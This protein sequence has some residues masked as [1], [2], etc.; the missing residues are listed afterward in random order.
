[1]WIET[2]TVEP[3]ACEI[4]TDEEENHIATTLRCALRQAL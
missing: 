1:M 2:T 3:C 4:T